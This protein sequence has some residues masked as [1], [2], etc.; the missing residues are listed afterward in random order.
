MP[1]LLIWR[2]NIVIYK[3]P[4]G[5]PGNEINSNKLQKIKNKKP[6][7]IS[8][9][10]LRMITILHWSA[11]IATLHGTWP[12][13]SGLDYPCLVILRWQQTQGR[14][15]VDPGRV[16]LSGAKHSMLISQGHDRQP[17]AL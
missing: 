9:S 12:V 3:P 7:P 10:V 11:F 4:P 1:N 5:E 6:T 16:T 17:Q 2:H 13:D 8:H 14:S 15:W